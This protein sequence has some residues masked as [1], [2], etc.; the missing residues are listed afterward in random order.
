MGKYAINSAKKPL[1]SG[2]NRPYSA[3]N[4]LAISSILIA[5]NLVLIS[6]K[7]Y[8]E[9]QSQMKKHQPRMWLVCLIKN[10]TVSSIRS[11]LLLINMTYVHMSEEHKI[12]S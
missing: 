7:G 6:S 1:F 12:C 10:K 4:L 5:L 3:N 11:H 8:P 2:L 9:I